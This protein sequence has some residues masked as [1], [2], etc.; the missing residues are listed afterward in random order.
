MMNKNNKIYDIY[1]DRKEDIDYFNKILSTFKFI[2]KNN[3][4]QIDQ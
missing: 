1:F 4:N 2:D 3:S